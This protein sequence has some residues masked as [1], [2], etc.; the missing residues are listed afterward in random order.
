MYVLHLLT[1]TL[2]R[3]YWTKVYYPVMEHLRQIGGAKKLKGTSIAKELFKSTC[4]AVAT[5]LI[6]YYL[7]THRSSVFQRLQQFR[8]LLNRAGQHILADARSFI[9]VSR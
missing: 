3:L 8:G 4:K 7:A 2:P 6:V 9:G 5:V 1:L